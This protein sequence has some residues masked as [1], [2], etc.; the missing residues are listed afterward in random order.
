MTGG[1]RPKK[2]RS[3]FRQLKFRFR[4]SNPKPKKSREEKRKE[5]FE[6]WLSFYSEPPR[7]NLTALEGRSHEIMARL[8]AVPDSK[9]RL[10]DDLW[11][12]L[13]AVTFLWCEGVQKERLAKVKQKSTLQ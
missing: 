7:N 5:L 1:S 4:S 10:L 9:P 11:A 12:Q 6:Y 8:Q 13:K 2:Q 3:R